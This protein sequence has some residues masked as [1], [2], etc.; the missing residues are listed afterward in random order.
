M[1]SVQVYV[2][3]IQSQQL[4][5]SF[6][7]IYFNAKCATLTLYQGNIPWLIIG[8]VR[9]IKMIIPVGNLA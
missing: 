1:K 3:Q 9:R 7:D 2:L 8:I 4:Q 5:I 6:P